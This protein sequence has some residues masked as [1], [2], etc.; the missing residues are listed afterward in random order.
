MQGFFQYM[1]KT[2]ELEGAS[3]KKYFSA[4]K[5]VIKAARRDNHIDASNVEFLYADVKITV[6]QSTRRVF[7]E[8]EEIRK[9]KAVEIPR[10]KAFLERDRD[11]FLFQIY[12]G[13]YYKDLR[14]MRKDQLMKDEEYGYFILGERDKNGNDT[15]IPLFKF[16]YAMTIM[17]RY[18]AA[19][20]SE[21]VFSPDAFIEEPVYNRNLKEIGKMAGIL[22][23]VY[24]KVGRHTNAQLYV[25]YG[26]KTSVVSKILGHTKEDTTRHYYRVD[27]PEIVEGTKNIDFV[28][29]GI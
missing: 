21:L 8:L 4:L 10:S 2:L 26:V 7:L 12:T 27:I 1:S 18:A 14:I 25:R 16:P 22:K 29:M 19:D 28:K 17:E 5:K 6:K 13:Y 3:I 9:W 24:N 11:M 15:I 23:P 20:S